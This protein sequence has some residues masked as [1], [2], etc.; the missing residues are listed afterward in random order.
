MNTLTG[1]GNVLQAKNPEEADIILF[2]DAG[3]EPYQLDVRRHSLFKAHQD[4]CFVLDHNDITVP[5][6]RGLYASLPCSMASE[7]WAGGGFF[8]GDNDEHWL[9][10][11]S[12][13]ER[14]WLFSFV[15]SVINHPVRRRLQTLISNESILIDTS[16][17]VIPAFSSGNS[18]E[19]DRLHRQFLEISH[20]SDFILCPRGVGASSIR[21]FEAMQMARCPVIIS[22]D[23]TP[24]G[25]ID[26]NSISI[27]IAEKEVEKIPCILERRRRHAF[28]MGQKAREVYD[29]CFA[30]P[31]RLQWIIERCL[32]MRQTRPR[33]NLID[34]VRPW[35]FLFRPQHMQHFM[36]AMKNRWRKA[37][38]P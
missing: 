3:S 5:F 2:S 9:K 26:W 29:A 19:I 4:K 27:R 32:I 13:E 10:Q 33:T 8:F 36:R 15:G 35:L 30:A 21:I 23:W 17:E 12:A 34:R 14:R 25:G 1:S 6:V 18:A 20:K 37:M 31:K 24:P 28:E 11:E 22:D 7:A 38:T 16:G